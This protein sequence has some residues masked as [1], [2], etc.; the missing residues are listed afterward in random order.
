MR[1]IQTHRDEQRAHFALKI[2]FNPASLRRV[3]LAMG[4]QPNTLGLQGGQQNIV[5]MGVLAL[6]QLVQGLRQTL[7]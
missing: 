4:N 7:E 5:V 3:A 6:D 2:L 1:R